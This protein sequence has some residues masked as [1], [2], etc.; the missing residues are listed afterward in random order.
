MTRYK[1]RIICHFSVRHS[2]PTNACLQVYGREWLSCHA[3][4]QDVSRC[5]SKGESP[6]MTIMY[7]SYQVHTRLPT[8]AWNPEKTS[9]EVTPVSTILFT[10]HFS[11]HQKVVTLFLKLSTITCMCM[12][13]LPIVPQWLTFLHF[14]TT[15]R[16][17]K[18]VGN[19]SSQPLR[20]TA[21]AGINFQ[22]TQLSAWKVCKLV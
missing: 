5:N 7:T 15:H 1:Q 22:G 10:N 2:S 9:P 20:D 13:K 3:G 17:I 21:M 8:M 14:L 16:F 11:C 19:Y 6:E 12:C 4:Y 18:A